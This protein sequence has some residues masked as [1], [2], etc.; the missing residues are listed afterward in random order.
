MGYLGSWVAS[1]RALVSLI[2]RAEGDVGNKFWRTRLTHHMKIV[3]NARNLELEGPTHRCENLTKSLQRPVPLP[4][5]PTF[6]LSPAEPSMGVLSAH[7]EYVM[8]V[9]IMNMGADNQRIRLVP[10]KYVGKEG[11]DGPPAQISVSTSSTKLFPGLAGCLTIR[12]NCLAPGAFAFEFGVVGEAEEYTLTVTGQVLTPDNF[13][14]LALFRKL[15]G[16]GQLDEGVVLVQDYTAE[17]NVEASMVD[18]SGE[19]MAPE[20]VGGVGEGSRVCALDSLYDADLLDDVKFWP[21]L[22]GVYFDKV[23]RAQAATATYAPL[24]RAFRRRWWAVFESVL[25]AF[26]P[27]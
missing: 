27:S 26:E 9:K 1:E 4:A 5:A 24:G 19:S 6:S 10:P 8:R 18:E 7:C 22:P 12:A 11:E 23:S 21:T 25:G 16:K 13:E 3:L 17:H 15:E 14:A 20:S 2:L